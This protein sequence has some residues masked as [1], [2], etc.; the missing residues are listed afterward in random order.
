MTSL[1]TIKP[2]SFHHSTVAPA[3]KHRRQAGEAYVDNSHGSVHVHPSRAHIHLRVWNLSAEQQML[4]RTI[5]LGGSMNAL[6]LCAGYL[7]PQPDR[8]YC[9]CSFVTS[10]IPFA[11]CPS[12]YWSRNA[13]RRHKTGQA[14]VIGLLLHM[15]EEQSFGQLQGMVKAKF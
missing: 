12:F 11:D 6:L 3:H 13:L 5:W 8:H 2:I 14:N 9:S 10:I 1:F 7:K 4:R 15:K